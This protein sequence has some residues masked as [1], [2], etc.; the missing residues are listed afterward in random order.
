M[1]AMNACLV[2]NIAL[3]AGNCEETTG[4]TIQPV[5]QYVD[6][7]FRPLSE[8]EVD[9]VQSQQDASSDGWRPK[10]S[11]SDCEQKSSSML[12]PEERGYR[13]LDYGTTEQRA[14]KTADALQQ[15]PDYRDNRYWWN[16]QPAY[17]SGYMP[18]YG[19]QGG[20]GAYGGYGYPNYSPAYPS[21]PGNSW[22]QGNS[23]PQGGYGG[24][25]YYSMPQF[26]PGYGVTPF[27]FGGSG[28]PW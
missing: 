25:P 18:G 5:A 12:E 26:M 6:E 13:P 22:Y 9:E 3:A 20:Y 19:S 27:G 7:G 2:S 24:N 23:W 10:S 11:D 14:D 17:G 8:E 16:T 4:F 28:L 15:L 1:C 21:A